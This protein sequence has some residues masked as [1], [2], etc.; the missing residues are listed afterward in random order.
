[1]DD[2]TV[3]YTFDKSKA[4][5]STCNLRIGCKIVAGLNQFVAASYRDPVKV[6]MSSPVCS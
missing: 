6:R 5:R 4:A 1:M 3:C 2:N